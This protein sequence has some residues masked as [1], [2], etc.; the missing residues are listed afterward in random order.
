MSKTKGAVTLKV[1]F[2]IVMTDVLESIAELFFKKGAL[3]TGIDNV[4]LSNFLDYTFKIICVPN[5]WGGVAFYAMNFVVW[6][7]V[8]SRV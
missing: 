6:I 7:V 4:T 3:A 8:L 5:L 2:L 1:F